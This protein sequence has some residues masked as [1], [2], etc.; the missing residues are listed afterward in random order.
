[1]HTSYKKVVKGGRPSNVDINL[2]WSA[3]LLTLRATNLQ[4]SQIGYKLEQ[5]MKMNVLLRNIYQHHKI[6][7]T[8][9]A[10][11]LSLT[12]DSIPWGKAWN[13]FFICFSSY[14]P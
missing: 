3:V 4:M 2:W 8:F 5:Y 14:F 1:M 12:D 9:F 6:I 11:L 13:G 10:M 7:R